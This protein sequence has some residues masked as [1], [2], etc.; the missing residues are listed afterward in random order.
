M[1]V[2]DDNFRRMIREE[3]RAAIGDE[4]GAI[5]ASLEELREG[6]PAELRGLMSLDQV[7]DYLGVKS[8]QTA[9]KW[10][11]QNRIRLRKIG[12]NTRVFGD[13]I[14]NVMTRKK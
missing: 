7:A 12:N 13:D 14:Y 3:V 8:T 1:S 5:R 6:T 4:L 10:C 2:L 9:R 11:N